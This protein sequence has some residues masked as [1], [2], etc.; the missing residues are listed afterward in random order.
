MCSGAFAAHL[1]PSIAL[2]EVGHVPPSLLD[3]EVLHDLLTA[4]WLM[5]G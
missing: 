4:T 5:G 1:L 2:E 3:L